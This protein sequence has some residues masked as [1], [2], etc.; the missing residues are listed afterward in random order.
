MHYTV[1]KILTNVLIEQRKHDITE[2]TDKHLPRNQKIRLQISTLSDG[3]V[4]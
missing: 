3:V 2:S 4:S 1:L